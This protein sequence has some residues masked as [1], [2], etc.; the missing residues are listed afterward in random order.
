MCLATSAY[1]LPPVVVDLAL[2]PEGRGTYEAVSRRPGLA[3]ADA[4]QETH[5]TRLNAAFGGLLHYTYCTPDFVMGSWLMEKR[6][7]ADWS[8]ISA[9]NRW[10]GVIFGGSDPDARV[11]PQCEGLRNGKTYNQYWSA[12]RRGTMIVAKLPDRTHS[13]QCGDLRLFVS[14][15]LDHEEAGGWLFVE[16][17]RAWLAARFVTAAENLSWD[18]ESWWRCRD[19][20]APLILEVVRKRDIPDLAAFQRDIQSRHCDLAEGRLTYAGRGGRFVF[21]VVGDSLPTIDGTPL[22]L[23]PDDTFRSPYVQETWDSGTVV[24]RKGKRE[25]SCVVGPEPAR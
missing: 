5:I 1:R 19:R 9:Q 22:N 15:G 13:H 11:Y 3:R 17:E 2:D 8:A 6:P 25:W 16:A 7:R 12:Q 24:I 10:Q 4:P 14:P 23:R 18:G 20:Q 21:D